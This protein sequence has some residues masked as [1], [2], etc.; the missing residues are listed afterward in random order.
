VSEILIATFGSLVALGALVVSFMAHRH[1]VARAAALD[2]RERRIDA[3]ERALE[4][5][6]RRIQASMIEVRMSVSPS[7]LHDGWVTPRLEIVNPSNQ[8]IKIN[9]VEY[10]GEALADGFGTLGSGAVRSISLPPLENGD[11]AD[12]MLQDITIALR[13]A[14]GAS[15]RRDGGGGLRRGYRRPNGVWVWSDRE[16][17][18]IAE[19]RSNDYPAPP[20]EAPTPPP[21]VRIPYARRMGRRRL[22]WVGTAAA[23]VVLAAI[24]IW[25]E[26]R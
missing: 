8:P 25:L 6:E 4:Q 19:S 21:T 15:W 18:V 12:M 22:V 13:D 7:S 5:R 24:G 10:R 20:R 11:H 3:R 9:F 23:V 14:A 1:Q 2:V 26:Y 16:D 17:P